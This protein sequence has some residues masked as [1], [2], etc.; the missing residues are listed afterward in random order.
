MSEIVIDL[1]DEL[2]CTRPDLAGANTPYGLLTHCLGVMAYWGGHVVAGRDIVRD[3][4]AEFDA[5]GTA[6]ELRAQ[7]DEALDQL[8]AE[9][10]AIHPLA[11]QRHEPAQSAQG[12]DRP[13]TQA[14]AMVHLYEEMAQHNSQTQVLRDARFAVPKIQSSEFRQRRAAPSTTFRSTGSAASER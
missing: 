4:S 13:L 7:V 2:A 10:A 6:D 14:A 11:P 12:P 3:R 1:G 5:T 8:H 9:L